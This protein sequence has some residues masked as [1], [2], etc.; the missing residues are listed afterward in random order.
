MMQWSSMLRHSS[1]INRTATRLLVTPRRCMLTLGRTVQ[2][3]PQYDTILTQTNARSVQLAPG[4]H[5]KS[6]AVTIGF[7][8]LPTVT[9]EDLTNTM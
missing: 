6:S 9:G 5:I 1:S 4:R 3:T 2:R 8:L 7:P